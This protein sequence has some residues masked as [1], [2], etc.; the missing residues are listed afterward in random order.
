MTDRD[1][2]KEFLS[3]EDVLQIHSIVIDR[4]GGLS[5]VR[6][7]GLLSSA[8]MM[9][10]QWFGGSPLHRDIAAIAAAYLFHICCN[11]AFIDGNKRTALARAITFLIDNGV[12]DL[13]DQD[14]AADI[15]IAVAAGHISKEEL[16]QWFRSMISKPEQP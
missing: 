2:P 6:D 14:E 9:P 13:P 4:D 12:T 10:Q 15:T 7:H 11:H 16:T 5:G 1:Q 3:V 8:V